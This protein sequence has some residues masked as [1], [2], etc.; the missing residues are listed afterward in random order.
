MA[1]EW[2]MYLS[3]IALGVLTIAGVTIT[4]NAISNSTLENTVE[5][6]LN[7]VVSTVAQE[8]KGVLELGL[9]SDPLTAVTINRTL[10]LPDDLVGH[11]YEVYFK[12][13]P[14]SKHWFIQAVDITSDKTSE[15]LF[16]TTLPWAD[17]TIQSPGSLSLPILSSTSDLQHYICF[18]RIEG[19][20]AFS[21][22]IL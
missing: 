3:V 10:D 1:S 16:E 12:I 19:A 14:S 22:I 4:F 15:I 5:V 8:L 6:G 2:V 7:E 9:Q 17:V 21:I 20:Q 11:D 18:F 13:Y